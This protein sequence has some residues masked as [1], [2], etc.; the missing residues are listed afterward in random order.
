MYNN[1]ES[2]VLNNGNSCNI[3]KVQRGVR[4]G[5]P[6]SAYLFIT[7]LETL[8]N[9][10]RNDKNV[11][12]IK[13]DKKE[14]KITLLVDDIAI[15]LVD[16]NSVKRCMEIPKCYVKCAGLIINVERNTAKVNR[17]SDR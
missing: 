12:G 3:F 4:Q 8:V 6:S 14:I 7:T 5:Y 16:L 11:K 13:I 1:V 10:I 17:V 2:T 15:I 9:K